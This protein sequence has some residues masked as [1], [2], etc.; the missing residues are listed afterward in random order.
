MLGK[1]HLIAENV[2]DIGING[3]SSGE[4]EGTVSCI[5]SS[6]ADLVFQLVKA[7]MNR[8]TVPKHL[9]NLVKFISKDNLNEAI[10]WN[11]DSYMDKKSKGIIKVDYKTLQE[12]TQVPTLDS[13]LNNTK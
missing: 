5:P 4:F 11:V 7:Y 10:P 1:Y 13:S 8:E 2:R 3:I 12:V 6:E 9:Y